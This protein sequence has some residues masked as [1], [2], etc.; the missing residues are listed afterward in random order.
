MFVVVV[1]VCDDVVFV[2]SGVASDVVD[3]DCVVVVYVYVWYVVDVV[4]VYVC[5][6]V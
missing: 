5:N 1:V 2:M 4:D 3:V 6:Y